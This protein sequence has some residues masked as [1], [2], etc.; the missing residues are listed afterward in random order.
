LWLKVAGPDDYGPTASASPPDAS[1]VRSG[2][3]AE[4]RFQIKLPDQA[5]D[6]WLTARP[7]NLTHE[8]Q[9]G[10]AVV[11][12]AELELGSDDLAGQARV[13]ASSFS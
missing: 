4:D 2:F 6:C 7:L 9:H 11:T 1:E 5:I 8:Q 10:V 13:M 3:Q 12:A